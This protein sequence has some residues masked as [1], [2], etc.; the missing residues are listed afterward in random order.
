MRLVMLD[1]ETTG[2][3]PK[4]GDRII[5]I[6]AIEVVE[7]VMRCGDDHVFHHYINPECNIRPEVVSIHGIDNA[8]VA[9]KPV[10]R[11]I[12]QDFLDFIDEATLVIHNTPFDLGFI[13]NELR[14]SGFPSIDHMPVIDSLS[15]ARKKHPN[16]LNN[17]DALCDRYRINRNRRSLHGALIDAELLAEVYMCLTGGVSSQA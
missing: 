12:A 4:R 8:K 16:E 7:R 14:L 9:N 17:L 2:L 15:L 10:F 11:E 1:T 6:G 5:E 13:N 3:L